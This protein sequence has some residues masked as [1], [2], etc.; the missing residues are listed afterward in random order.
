MSLVLSDIQFYALS[1][2][3]TILVIIVSIIFNAEM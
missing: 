2:T 1:E 3:F